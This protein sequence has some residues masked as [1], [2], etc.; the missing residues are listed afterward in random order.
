[1]HMVR[2]DIHCS[3]GPSI[4]S[5][6]ATNLL[7]KNR[8]DLAN[9]NLFALGGTADKMVS[10][11]VGDMFGVLRIHTRQYNMCSHSLEEPRRAALPL[12]ES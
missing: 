4:L 8:G 2:L 11:L 12:D 5:T 3:N 7:F 6:D 9:E 1:M 10:Q